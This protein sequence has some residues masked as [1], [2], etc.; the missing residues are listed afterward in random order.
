MRLSPSLVSALLT[1]SLMS[2]HLASAVDCP[3]QRFPVPVDCLSAA[4]CA[5]PC[6]GNC[7]IGTPL[8][9]PATSKTIC[10]INFLNQSIYQCGKVNG[11]PTNCPSPLACS[12]NDQLV[13]KY[14]F[15]V[16]YCD[17][18]PPTPPPTA[19]PAPTAAPTYNPCSNAPG[20]SCI[21]TADCSFGLVRGSAGSACSPIMSP[22][23]TASGQ[24]HW[25]CAQCALSSPCKHCRPVGSH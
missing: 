12:G 16:D 4:D 1:I 22:I 9:T 25:Q 3:N 19:P 13:A 10:G 17:V 20:F 21:N 6:N 11:S 8:A 7:K 2:A 18:A 14:I 23:A 24:W 5:T 15:A